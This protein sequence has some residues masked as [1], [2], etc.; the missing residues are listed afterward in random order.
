MGYG[1][2]GK[3]CLG[4]AVCRHSASRGRPIRHSSA[5]RRARA[6]RGSRRLP[7][8]G[9]ADGALRDGRAAGGRHRPRGS[10]G[11][12]ASHAHRRRAAGWA[13]LH[14]VELRV[15]EARADRRSGL[16]MERAPD[17]AHR[18]REGLGAASEVPPALA[19][20]QPRQEP[21]RNFWFK[22][23]PSV[24]LPQRQPKTVFPPTSVEV[25]GTGGVPAPVLFSGTRVTTVPLIAGVM[26]VA[27][28]CI[29]T[30]TVPLASV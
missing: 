13:A 21:G 1:I 4:N 18:R 27:K 30:E 19:V 8:R 17:A 28:P 12:R 2:S 7:A 15:L 14:V 16:R 26:V 20:A 9:H 23:V 24:A 10:G 6:V 22:V 5:R 29:V 25:I 11:A 3:A